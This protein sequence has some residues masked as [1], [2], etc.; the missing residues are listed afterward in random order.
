MIGTC[1]EPARFW[2]VVRCDPDGRFGEDGLVVAA[3]GVVGLDGW[4]LAMTLEAGGVPGGSI[5]AGGVP[6]GALTVN[7]SCCPFSSVA[8]TL[9]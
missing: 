1:C 5:C 9:H 6:G 3:G 4:Q 8:V 7:D 2:R